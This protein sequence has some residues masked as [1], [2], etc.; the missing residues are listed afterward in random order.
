MRLVN[1]G[2]AAYDL[3]FAGNSDKHYKK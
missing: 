2:E 3:R 1:A